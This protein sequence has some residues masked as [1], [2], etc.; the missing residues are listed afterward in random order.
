MAPVGHVPALQMKKD[1]RVI[2]MMDDVVYLVVLF[3]GMVKE[4]QGWLSNSPLDV[5]YG[6]N[7]TAE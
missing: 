4:D 1:V 6:N 7:I 5:E 3:Y 2:S